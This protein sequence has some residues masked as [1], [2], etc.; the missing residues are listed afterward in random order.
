MASTV[1]S[2]TTVDTV[3]FAGRS[4]TRWPVYDG[5]TL[6]GPPRGDFSGGKEELLQDLIGALDNPTLLSDVIQ[7]LSNT[8]TS[9]WTD[10]GS[11]IN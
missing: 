11:R 9:T 8:D 7:R 5:T 4:L 3:A 6:A 2:T 1:H 10:V